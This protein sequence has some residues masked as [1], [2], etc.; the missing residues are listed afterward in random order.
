MIVLQRVYNTRVVLMCEHVFYSHKI[1]GSIARDQDGS[2]YGRLHFVVFLPKEKR[3]AGFLIKRPDIALMFRRKD[4]FIPFDA[5]ISIE[6]EF[7]FD[8][9]SHLVGVDALKR[10][11][12]NIHSCI[13][14]DG[15]FAVTQSG[16]LIGQIS[17]VIFSKDEGEIVKVLIGTAN[18]ARDLL[19]GRIALPASYIEG[20]RFVKPETFEKLGINK[21]DI[22]EGVIIVKDEVEDIIVQ[23]GLIQQAST[24]ASSI[25]SKIKEEAEHMASA[26][27][28]KSKTIKKGVDSGVYTAGEK[29]SGIAGMFSEFKEEY[30]KAAREDDNSL[31]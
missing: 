31:S 12:I 26:F 22:T 1:S 24:T 17:S 21:E 8:A 18:M 23:K 14:W 10:K 11:G 13:I 7:V 3:C 6:D 2:S 30:K 20:F 28:E 19:F 25:T 9:E 15:M 5:V 16:K 27:Q 4:L 29:L